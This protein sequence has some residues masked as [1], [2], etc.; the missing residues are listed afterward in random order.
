[1]CLTVNHTEHLIFPGQELIVNITITDYFGKPASCTADVY[2]QCDNRLLLCPLPSQQ[3][4]LKGPEAVVLAQAEDTTYSIID[5]SHILESSQDIINSSVSVLLRCRN[6][7]STKV[8][9]PAKYY[10]LP[11]GVLL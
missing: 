7:N 1:M 2:L 10:R 4:K 11:S 3:V 8:V 5:T 9:I 6:N